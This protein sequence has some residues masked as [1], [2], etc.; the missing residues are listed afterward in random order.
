MFFSG[1][2]HKELIHALN[3]FLKS[4][5]CTSDT[6]KEDIKISAFI[7]KNVFF[8]VGWVVTDFSSFKPYDA[9]HG[10]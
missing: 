4:I 9:Y 1:L 8:L 7:P 5:A 3:S 2:M 6:L 10:L